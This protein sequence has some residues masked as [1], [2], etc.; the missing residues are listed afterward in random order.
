M[1]GIIIL[2]SWVRYLR[3]V[4]ER[5]RRFLVFDFLRL[6][7]VLRTRRRLTRLLRPP[8]IWLVS[9]NAVFP[10]KLRKKDGWMIMFEEAAT[11]DDMVGLYIYYLDIYNQRASLWM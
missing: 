9:Y 4:F 7:Q 3:S 11:D 1:I 5:G 10:P 6:L 2:C 8:F